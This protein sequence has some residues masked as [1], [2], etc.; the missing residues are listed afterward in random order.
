MIKSLTVDEAVKDWP[1]I[2]PLLSRVLERFD[3]GSD[4]ND[5]LA[6]VMSGRRMIWSINN[7]EGVAVL[8]ICPLPKFSVLDVP[9]LA[10]D[11]MK[12]WLSPLIRQLTL[13]AKSSG[14]KY[15]DAFGRRG[16]TRQLEEYGFKPYSYDVRLR[17]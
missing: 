15:I 17:L 1:K 6:D 16:W 4:A 8:E 12:N 5:V 9:L 13:Y 3:Y 2:E 7:F 14:C 11:N 10:G